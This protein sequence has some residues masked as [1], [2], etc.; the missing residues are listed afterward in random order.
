MSSLFV[1]PAVR[2]VKGRPSEVVEMLDRRRYG[3]TKSPIDIIVDL[4]SFPRRRED[5]VDFVDALVNEQHVRSLTLRHGHFPDPDD[6][7]SCWWETSIR[8]RRRRHHVVVDLYYKLFAEVIPSKLFLTQLRFEDCT[9][10]PLS[11]V[12]LAAAMAMSP[13]RWTKLAFSNT[14]L[15]AEDLMAI[16]AMLENDV[17][18]TELEFYNIG[19]QLSRGDA[20]RGIPA[21]VSQDFNRISEGVAKNQHVRKLSIR[22][23]A[24]F[25]TIQDDPS[26]LAGLVVSDARL[27]HL[28]VQVAE[29]HE[30]AVSR[31]V[32]A[33]QTNSSLSEFHLE[34]RQS[35]SELSLP[36]ELFKE[37]FCHHNY[38]LQTFQ[39]NRI[40]PNNALRRIPGHEFDFDPFRTVVEEHPYTRRVRC[41]LCRNAAV[42]ERQNQLERSQYTVVSHMVSKILGDISRFPT[43]VFRFLLRHPSVVQVGTPWRPIEMAVG[44]ECL[45]DGGQVVSAGVSTI[46]PVHFP[47]PCSSPSPGPT[48]QARRPN[49]PNAHKITHKRMKLNT[50]ASTIG[51]PSGARTDGVG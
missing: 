28:V 3:R 11:L 21:F 7:D 20:S 43:L 41:L 15:F 23:D 1:G 32:N 49:A 2:L 9:L 36:F 27:T 47:S 34:L 42:R 46:L 30:E 31:L 24:F 12:V 6:P 40:R 10:G 48:L 18:I 51:S 4:G 19:R 14:V 39:L 35:L 13:V 37:T 8:R 38:S 26:S 5:L 29:V 45:E 33:L 44:R 50:P 22:E 17:D 25:S 16:Q